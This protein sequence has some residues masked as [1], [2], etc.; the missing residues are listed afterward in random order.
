MA[1]VKLSK[2]EGQ[3]SSIEEAMAGALTKFG[4]LGAANNKT[5]T[6]FARITSGSWAWRFQARLRAM[7]N[8]V[9]L[10]NN[11]QKEANQ[12]MIDGIKVRGR[13]A[14][15]MKTTQTQM[16]KIGHAQQALNHGM[17][18]EWMF[19]KDE[20]MQGL[21]AETGN[22]TDALQRAHNFYKGLNEQGEKAIEINKKGLFR[23][24]ADKMNIPTL[25]DIKEK[26]GVNE[27]FGEFAKRTAK[28]VAGLPVKATK[29]VGEMALGF[30]DKVG[31][32]ASLGMKFLKPALLYGSV[33]LLGLMVVLKWLIKTGPYFFEMMGNI[34]PAFIMFFEGIWSVLKGLFNIIA[35]IWKGDFGQ[36]W[37]GLSQ[38]IE[39]VIKIL[40]GAF[41][42][43]AG[44]VFVV[45]T[46]M[47]MGV[48][49]AIWDFG[50]WLYNKTLGRFL[51]KGGVAQGGMTM[52]GEKGPELV[53]L[54]AGSRVISNANSRGMGGNTINVHVNG[55]V[56]ASDAEIR[57][58][59]N[60]V[61]REINI[62]MN[63]QG[64]TMMGG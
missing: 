11:A 44:T 51:S 2:L 9:E 36:I 48:V 29:K 21:I 63:R 46:A 52:V 23:Y 7:S 33:I 57:D 34:M 6:L 47:W 14:K 37:K 62:R 25:S 53:K 5:W 24:Y 30:M 35:G 55:R 13:L 22:W 4:E 17:D 18:I 15:A 3:I 56:G 32:F 39:G 38:I 28:G 43:F 8:F 20:V 59:A 19:E 42:A 27:G 40:L 12:E 64:T 16:E 41:S 10:M 61:A 50:K 31:K 58:I 54:P 45:I 26:M 49:Q 60:K 1:G